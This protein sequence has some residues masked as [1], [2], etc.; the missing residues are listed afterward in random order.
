MMVKD[1]FQDNYQ[2]WYKRKR[3][4]DNKK[5]VVQY[6]LRKVIQDAKDQVH[7]CEVITTTNNIPSKLL[8]FY[9]TNFQKSL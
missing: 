5:Q 6:R 9:K 8:D 2:S 3:K 1:N 7:D 4:A